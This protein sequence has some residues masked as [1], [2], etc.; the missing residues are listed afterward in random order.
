MKH[1]FELNRSGKPTGLVFK[2]SICETA[3]DLRYI[4]D[5]WAYFLMTRDE[6]EPGFHAAVGR[7]DNLIGDCLAY[8]GWNATTWWEAQLATESTGELYKIAALSGR[9]ECR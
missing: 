8:H 5:A 1:V 9:G 4:Q 2:R 6:G 7:K 3:F